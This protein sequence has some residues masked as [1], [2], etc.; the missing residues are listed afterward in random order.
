MYEILRITKQTEPPFSYFS[1]SKLAVFHP[2]FNTFFQLFSPV[3][4]KISENEKEDKI[5][6]R[7]LGQGLCTKKTRKSAMFILPKSRSD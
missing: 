5:E 2:L 1:C 3:K 6:N 4:I 7:Q